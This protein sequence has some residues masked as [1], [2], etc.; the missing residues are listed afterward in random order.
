MVIVWWNFHA[1]TCCYSIKYTQTHLKRY[2]KS[3]DSVPDE[4]SQDLELMRQLDDESH[5]AM[6]CHRNS[7]PMFT[8][9]CGPIYN[10]CASLLIV[11]FRCLPALYIFDVNIRI[12]AIL[13]D[14]H[15]LAKTCLDRPKH[16]RG[17]PPRPPPEIINQVRMKKFPVFL[18]CFYLLLGV[19]LF[20]S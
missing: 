20:A 12:A 5:G 14:V 17:R 6:H 16:K 3:L 8:M 18:F 15:N 19:C 10:V 2:L 11:Y 9:I 4:L 13:F 7:I 1:P